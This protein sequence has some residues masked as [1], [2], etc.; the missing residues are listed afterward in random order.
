MGNMRGGNAGEKTKKVLIVDD[1]PEMRRLIGGYLRDV[2]HYAVAE[3]GSGF[4][5]LGILALRQFDLIISD[6]NMP[7][8]RG[9]ELLD[10]VKE[11]FPA[12][13]RVL[14]TA[15]DVEGYF[16]LAIKYDIGNIFAKTAPFNFEELSVAIRNLLSNDI[17]GLERYFE[18]AAERMRF[19]LRDARSLDRYA[20]KITEFLGDRGRAKHLEV[21]AL[22]LLTNAVFYGVRRESPER[23]EQWDLDGRLPCDKTIVVTAARDREKYG[24][25]VFDEGGRLKKEDVLYWMHRQAR[26]DENGLP[27]GVG[28]AHGRGLFIAR[29][30]CDR[31]VINV[32]SGK[33]TEVI[34]INY[35]GRKYSGHKP[36]YINEL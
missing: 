19:S 31:L 1:E 30:Y 6:I 15:Y 20:R 26:R 5:A 32:E 35:F 29:R 34:I 22:E 24:L 14:I 4:E 12:M 36:L 7:G 21:G 33:R 9:F 17:F 25:S 28:D 18:A 8:M 16:E 13:R 10:I 3:A 23:K 11:R 2:E 27:I